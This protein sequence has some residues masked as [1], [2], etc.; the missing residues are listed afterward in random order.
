M[1]GGGLGVFA[2]VS[3][4]VV[5]VEVAEVSVYVAGTR[6]NEVRRTAQDSVAV[7]RHAL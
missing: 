2:P 4:R 6:G 1:D 5:H 7:T 3:R